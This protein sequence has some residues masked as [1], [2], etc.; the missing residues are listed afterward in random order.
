MFHRILYC[1]LLCLSTNISL[2]G[3]WWD[4]FESDDFRVQDGP[5]F[6]IT[7]PAE[8]YF[9]EEY[10]RTATA[11]AKSSIL[12]DSSATNFRLG[13]EN[14]W[15]ILR[16]GANSVYFYD[17]GSD[18]ASFK[19]GL[20]APLNSANGGPENIFLGFGVHS[21]GAGQ[22]TEYLSFVGDKMTSTGIARSTGWHRAQFSWVNGKPLRI[23]LDNKLMGGDITTTRPLSL[24]SQTTK[25]YAE[26]TTV[27]VNGSPVPTRVWLDDMNGINNCVPVSFTEDFEGTPDPTYWFNN[28]DRLST[29]PLSSLQNHTAEVGTGNSFSLQVNGG[30]Y[31]KRVIG[32]QENRGYFT[33]YFY[34]DGSSVTQFQVSAVAYDVS[35]PLLSPDRYLGIA[36]DDSDVAS[37]SGY[38]IFRRSAAN[39]FQLTPTGIQRTSG[40]HKLE[41]GT[42]ATGPGLKLRLDDQEVPHNT[43]TAAA[44]LASIVIF[45]HVFQPPYPLPP[46]ADH[47]HLYVDDITYVFNEDLPDPPAAAHRWTDY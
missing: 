34:D 12:L 35:N 39:P 32:L 47:P 16:Q 46:G 24:E 6:E 23:M 5:Y 43:E 10:N 36:V 2:A 25:V 44:G 3:A 26:S 37:S 7:G 11:G 15:N 13:H 20:F 45:G 4:D 42:Y 31:F 28:E 33:L 1:L 8:S 18:V 21:T 30:N 29:L 19:V 41:I 40:W 38:Q 17:D 22:N 14:F 27:V 9:T